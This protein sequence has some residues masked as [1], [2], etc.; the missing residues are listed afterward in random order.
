MFSSELKVIYI[1][2]KKDTFDDNKCI[3]HTKQSSPYCSI[4]DNSHG[5][6]LALGGTPYIQSQVK[7][8]EYICLTICFL[9]EVQTNTDGALNNICGVEL[10]VNGVQAGILTDKNFITQFLGTISFLREI[11]TSNTYSNQSIQPTFLTFIGL[12]IEELPI[13]DIIFNSKFLVNKYIL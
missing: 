11:T 2:L 13:E 8:G 9:S 5:Y 10:F 3:L 4:W 12:G 7:T 6:Q 1:V